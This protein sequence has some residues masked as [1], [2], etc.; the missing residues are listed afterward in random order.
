MLYLKN[1]NNLILNN[2]ILSKNNENTIINI[3]FNKVIY[4]L[5]CIFDL[6]KKIEISYEKKKIGR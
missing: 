4:T 1:L 6:I 5:E 2:I 3:D